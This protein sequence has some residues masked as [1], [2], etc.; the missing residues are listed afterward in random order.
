MSAKKQ[1]KDPVTLF[2]A[3]ESK[4]Y[5]VIRRIAFKERRSISSIAREAFDMFIKSKKKS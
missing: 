5:E 3:V 1:L 4:Q 2:A